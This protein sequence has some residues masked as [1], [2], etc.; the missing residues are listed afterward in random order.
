MHVINGNAATNMIS[1]ISTYSQL[2]PAPSLTS[3]WYLPSVEELD[4]IFENKDDINSSLANVGGTALWIEAFAGLV[5]VL[6][7]RRQ[8]G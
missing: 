4:I 5:D 6:P 8:D 1:N 7:I 2:M 3:G